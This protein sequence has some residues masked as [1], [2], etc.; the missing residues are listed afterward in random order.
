MFDRPHPVK[1]PELLAALHGEWDFCHCCG[2][3]RH[4]A[5]WQRL[6]L[7][8]ILK[9]GRS[10]ERTNLV[11]LCIRDHQLAEFHSI[12]ADNGVLLPYLTLP[13]VLWL[14]K[15]IDPENYDRQRLQQLYGK[16]LPVASK[17]PLVFLREWAR[18]QGSESGY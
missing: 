10:D 8:H 18:W 11:L 7:H 4:R 6:E 9:S 13:R 16:R 1:N 12:R 15:R 3:P 5:Q 17:P 2:I 14:K